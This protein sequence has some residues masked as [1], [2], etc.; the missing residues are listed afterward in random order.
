MRCE[1]ALE[2][3]S[4]YLDETTS[5]ALR[6]AL[7]HHYTQCHACNQEVVTLRRALVLFKEQEPVEVPLGFRSRVLAKAEASLAERSARPEGLRRLLSPSRLGRIAYRS[8]VG[9]A[10]LAVLTAL[11]Q[12]AFNA[13]KK[14]GW[15]SPLSLSAP[16]FEAPLG[17]A[18][19][20]EVMVSSGNLSGLKVG[21]TFSLTFD[22]LPR[23]PLS[24]GRL[25][26]DTP[27]GVRMESHGVAQADGWE[28]VWQGDAAQWQPQSVPIRF[29][30]TAPGVHV[31]RAKLVDSSRDKQMWVYV[32]V[33]TQP[34]GVETLEGNLALDTVFRSVASNFGVVVA[35]DNFYQRRQAVQV[36]L[37][38]PAHAA[39]SIC[40]QQSRLRWSPNGEAINI[41]YQP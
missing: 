21:S 13:A 41:Y 38:K 24:Q 32:P 2:N 22:L 18:R 20:P 16:R 17:D 15:V 36:S 12:T 23:S 9:L 3:L 8:A 29:R 39:E 10:A 34:D 25:I 26:I 40:R 14:L 27:S 19:R 31:L 4:D 1:Q 35:T 30:A 7:E 33:A 28:V 6:V 37:T 5:P 11:P